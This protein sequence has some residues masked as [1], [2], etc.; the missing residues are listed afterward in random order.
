MDYALICKTAQDLG[1]KLLPK[2]PLAPGDHYFAH[3]NGPVKLLT[4]G[5]I[6]DGYVV[7]KEPDYC[8]DIHECVKTEL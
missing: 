1:A 2:E 7:P 4:V 5:T 8:Y 6:K 3:R